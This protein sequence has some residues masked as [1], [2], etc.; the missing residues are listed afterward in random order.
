MIYITGDTHI[1]IDTHKLTTKC[2]P[3]QKTMTKSDYLIICG[4]FGGVWDDSNEEYYW[5]KWFFGHY[6]ID[7]HIDNKHIALFNSIELL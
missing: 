7:S 2:F 3:Q 1:P 5:R 6:H 4:D